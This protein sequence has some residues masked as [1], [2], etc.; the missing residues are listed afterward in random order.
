METAGLD[1]NIFKCHSTRSATVSAVKKKGICHAI[2]VKTAGWR[3][4]AVFGNFMIDLVCSCFD[5]FDLCGGQKT[6]L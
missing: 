3:N 6:M 4:T 5:V 1:K 2:I